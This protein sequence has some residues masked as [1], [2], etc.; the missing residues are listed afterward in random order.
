MH[1]VNLPHICDLRSLSHR[2]W[3]YST[4]FSVSKCYLPLWLAVRHTDRTPRLPTALPELRLFQY[5]VPW[6][7]ARH[8]YAYE[9][10]FRPDA[11]S[12]QLP[13]MADAASHSSAFA[14]GSV[15][16]LGTVV[17][18]YAAAVQSAV[19]HRHGLMVEHGWL[20]VHCLWFMYKLDRL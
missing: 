16:L 12:S 19:R 11:V 8:P 4:H 13:R 7:L 20:P 10:R 17:M 6:L 14:I 5:S 1:I 2:H 9:R 18:T 15:Q 3:P